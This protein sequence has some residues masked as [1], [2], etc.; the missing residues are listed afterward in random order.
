V[1]K[2][3]QVATEDLHAP[4]LRVEHPAERVVGSRAYLA[5]FVFAGFAWFSVLVGLV[6][7]AIATTGLLVISRTSW[8]G[9]TLARG[10]RSGTEPKRT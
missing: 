6:T 5:T 4:E 1:L 7:A 2:R 3:S 9:G 8:G 10:C